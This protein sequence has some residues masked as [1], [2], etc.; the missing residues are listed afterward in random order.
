MCLDCIECKYNLD[1]NKIEYESIDITKSLK[2]LKELIKLRDKEAVFDEAKE[3][4][5]LGIPALIAE[6]GKITLDWENFFVELKIEVAYPEND[7]AACRIDGTG[8]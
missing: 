1:K 2:G 3:K 6:D 5:Y 4:G 8:C 7:A